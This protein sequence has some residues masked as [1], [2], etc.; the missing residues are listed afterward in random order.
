[1][2]VYRA[3][4]READSADLR[5]WRD[6]PVWVEQDDLASFVVGAEHQ[7]LRDER[8]DLLRREV[9][10]RDHPP[11]DQLLGPVVDRDLRA[12]ALDAERAEVDPEAVRRTPRLGARAS[13]GD[14]T[15][16]HVD[17]LEVF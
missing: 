2:R 16:P 10:D 9:D 15:H 14:D 12:R 6:R 7:H 4:A 17:L 1:M 11:A 5:A 8:A 13:V 3:P